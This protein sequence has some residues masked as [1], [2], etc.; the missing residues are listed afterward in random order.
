MKNQNYVVIKQLPDANIGTHVIWSEAENCYKYFKSAYVSPNDITYLTAG[1]VTQTPE[2]FC[3]AIEYPEYYGYHFPVLSRGEVLELV[4]KYLIGDK[5]EVTYN[6]LESIHS[7]EVN[8]RDLA[9]KN[10][11]KLRK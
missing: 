3:K 2:F 6:K 1:Q 8:L 4:K 5:D 9:E 7:F 10:A 11:K